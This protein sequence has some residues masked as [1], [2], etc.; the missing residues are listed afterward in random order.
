MSDGVALTPDQVDKYTKHRREAVLS[1][2]VD[3]VLAF[4][5]R[6]GIKN[7]L[8]P[9]AELFIKVWA[10]KLKEEDGADSGDRSGEEV[11]RA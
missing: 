4:F 9:Q 11:H 2:D 8:R 1:G 5:E 7:V 10:P 6:W 3:L